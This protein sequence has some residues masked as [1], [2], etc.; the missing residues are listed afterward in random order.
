MAAN[1]YFRSR[2]DAKVPRT[3]Q[4]A[5]AKRTSAAVGDALA[6]AAGLR[7]WC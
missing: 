5:L 7:C 4:R 3:A 6:I 2:L 1:R